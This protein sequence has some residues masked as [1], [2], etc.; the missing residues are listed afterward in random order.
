MFLLAA[1]KLSESLR[2]PPGLSPN[3]QT[4]VPL[5]ST[6]VPTVNTNSGSPSN[7]NFNT[8]A[9]YQAISINGLVVDSSSVQPT[10]CFSY[11][12]LKV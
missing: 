8:V 4:K 5:I 11:F 10:R 12:I 9:D 2:G 7:V 1:S 3:P 6:L